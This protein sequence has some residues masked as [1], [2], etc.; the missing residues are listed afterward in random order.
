MVL[1]KEERGFVEPG[2]D[3]QGKIFRGFVETGGDVKGK[4]FSIWIG[5][6]LQV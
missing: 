1:R 3:V 2:G 5:T 4:I 6:C